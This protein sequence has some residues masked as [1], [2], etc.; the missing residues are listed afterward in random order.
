MLSETRKYIL[1]GSEPILGSNPANPKV[2]EAYIESK[3]PETQT[4]NESALTPEQGVGENYG[5]TVFLRHPETATPMVFDYTVRGFLKEA[6]LTLA[7]QLGLVAPKSKVDKYLFVSPR[8]IPLQDKDLRPAEIG[9]IYERP[10][11]AMTMQGPRVAL[12]GSE[13]I[14]D[15]QIVIELTLLNNAG[16]KNKGSVLDWTAVEEA[17]DYGR[18]QGLGQFRNG[19][20]GRFTWTRAEN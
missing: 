7:P 18:L 10:L 14:N 13:I 1:K 9:G 8:H 15:W 11:R 20:F 3:K 6:L 4:E 16:G 17:L 2:R 19:G 12:A 5:L